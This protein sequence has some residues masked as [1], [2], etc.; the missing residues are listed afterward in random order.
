VKQFKLVKSRFFALPNVLAGEL[1]VPE[2][3]QQEV[4]GERIAQEVSRWLEQPALC[5]TLS[6]RFDQLHRQLKTDAA[7]TAATAVLQHISSLDDN[8]TAKT[9]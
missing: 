4:S 2:L 3:L 8:N 6:Q 1:L 9:G 7:A 5:R